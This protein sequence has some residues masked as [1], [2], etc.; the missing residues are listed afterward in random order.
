MKASNGRIRC[1]VIPCM[2]A[3]MCP[4]WHLRFYNVDDPT[5]P[6]IIRDQGDN[7]LMVAPGEN[8]LEAICISFAVDRFTSPC[9]KEATG[10][11]IGLGLGGGS[12]A[13]GFVY[14]G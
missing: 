3:F 13:G 14:T 6:A 5:N 4:R 11:G 12:T 10:L 8:L 2:I 7:T 1:A 9:T